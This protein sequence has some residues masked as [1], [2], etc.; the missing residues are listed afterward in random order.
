MKP[1]IKTPTPDRLISLD[2]F[3]GVTIAGMTL[4][5]NPGTWSAVYPPLRHAEWHGWTPTDLVFP[6]FLFIVGVAMTFSFAKVADA[7]RGRLYLK[8]LRRSALLFAIGLFLNVFPF[9]DIAN[10]RIPGVLQRIAVCYLLASLITVN[11]GLKGRIG[12]F[13]GLLLGYWAIMAWIPVPGHG[14]GQLT[15]EGNP[16]AYLDNLLLHGHMYRETWDPEGI[17]ST[18]PSVATVLAGVLTGHLVRSK[19]PR[20]EIAGWM[21]TL[22]WAGILL[23]LFWGIWFPINKNIWTSSY[24]VFTAGA[25]LQFLGVCYWLVDVQ[26]WKKTAFPAVV[27]GVNA[28][29]LYVLSGLVTELTVIDFGGQS[30]KGWV[31]QNLLASWLSPINA[32]LAFGLGYV[33]LWWGVMYVFYRK[34]VFIKL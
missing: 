18:I 23:G 4:V 10:I 29:A 3:R 22:G 26:G 28:L 5:N 15:E 7:D 13:W 33:A 14:A 30:L 32:S 8:I 31:Y 9:F 34:N 6:F 27:F 12:W 24:V 16:A 1:E 19:K 11:T 21:F 17:L 25:A 2:A 20:P